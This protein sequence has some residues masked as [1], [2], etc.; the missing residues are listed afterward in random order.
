MNFF[1]SWPEKLESIGIHVLG[2]VSA[3]RPKTYSKYCELT[4]DGVPAGLHYLVRN[5]GCR[6]GFESIMPGTQ[7]IVCCGI[8]MPEFSQ[9]APCR[10]A[11]FCSLGDYHAV[12]KDKLQQIDHLLRQHYPIRHS[13]VCVDS[14]P[15]L[16]RELAVRA[17]IGHIGFN[18]MVIHPQYGSWLALGELLIDVD[19]CGDADYLNY[20][21]FPQDDKSLVPGGCHCCTA[22]HRLCVQ[23][24]P[25]GALSDHGYDMNRC[26]SYWSTQHKGVIPEVYA[27]AMGNV[28]WGCDRCQLNCPKNTGP[29]ITVQNS[30]ASPLYHLTLRDILKSS[31]KALQRMLEGS[32]LAD[33][34]PCMV[35]R[36]AC[37]IIGNTGHTEVAGLLEE[38]AESHHCDWVRETAQQSI[39]RIHHEH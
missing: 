17:G 21:V 14:A 26:V 8:A 13:R 25:T 34:H 36:N 10:Y 11:R 32:P 35:Q 24:C 30:Y 29:V 37:I 12:L 18:H 38:V 31:G 28:L 27:M 15:V 39:K 16:E 4:G 33:A 19:L 23:S 9:A 1:T 20:H 5:A 3:I 6:A 22:G 7:S 2:I